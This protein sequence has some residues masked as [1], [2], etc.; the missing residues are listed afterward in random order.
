MVVDSSALIAIELEEP[1]WEDLV[2]K[3]A[4]AQVALISA[5][6]LLE[7]A[8]VVSR[9]ADRDTSS[10]VA[11]LLRE[12]GIDVATFTEHHY[13]A[14]IEAFL[15][16]GKGRH[17]AALNSAIAWHTR[18]PQSQGFHCCTSEKISRRPISSR[19][20]LGRRNPRGAYSPIIFTSARFRLRP[21]NSP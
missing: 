4:T 1:G 8:M 14:A 9:R 21:S 11:D 16:Y 6:T 20:E 10:I 5:P 15:R 13:F 12:F 17:P 18:R 19:L 2:A 3:I 7:T